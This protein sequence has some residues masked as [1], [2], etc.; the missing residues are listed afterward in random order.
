ME[1]PVR[2]CSSALRRRGVFGRETPVWAHEQLISPD[3]IFIRVKILSTPRALGGFQRRTCRSSC[4]NSN[5]FDKSWLICLVGGWV[6]GFL[7]VRGENMPDGDASTQLQKSAG[8]WGRTGKN[9]TR[10]YW[11]SFKCWIRLRIKE[12]HHVSLYFLFFF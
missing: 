1:D 2:I 3:R 9:T 7:P 5:C 10:R 12:K 8:I 6:G 4:E 11:S